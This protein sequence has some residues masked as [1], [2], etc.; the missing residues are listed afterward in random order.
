MFCIDLWGFSI[1][2]LILVITI[3]NRK[4][5]FCVFWSF[6]DLPELKLTEAFSNMNSF[7]WGATWEEEVQEWATRAQMSTGGMGPSAGHATHARLALVPPVSSVFALDCSAWPKKF[8]IKTPQSVLMRR[9]RINTKPWN[10][11]YSSEDWRGNATEV[12]PGRFSKLSNIT[13]TATMIIKRE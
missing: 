4:Y 1:D 13:N 12:A 2:P 10:R 7:I 11:C 6:G 8:Y 5:L 3:H 9:R